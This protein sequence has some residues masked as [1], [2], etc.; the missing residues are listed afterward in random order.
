MDWDEIAH[1][2][3]HGA[4]GHKH[5]KHS[6]KES[7][8]NPGSKYRLTIHNAE[9]SGDE[10]RFHEL[11]VNVEGVNHKGAKKHW[12]TS[13]HKLHLHDGVTRVE[14]NSHHNW[15]LGDFQKWTVKLTRHV[16]HG[17][18][19]DPSLGYAEIQPKAV[20]HGT[21]NVSKGGLGDWTITYSVQ[22]RGAS[23]AIQSELELM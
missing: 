4:V 23:A 14:W 12:K 20:D 5:S 18:N 21:F 7:S 19:L 2:A 10:T 15:V 16:S 6:K 8:K 1:T 9:A 11:S 3:T 13:S 17:S 22:P